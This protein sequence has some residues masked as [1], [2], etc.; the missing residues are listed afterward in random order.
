MMLV[1]RRLPSASAGKNKIPKA[2]GNPLEGGR[3]AAADPQVLF[4]CAQ[5]EEVLRALDRL[6]QAAQKLLKIGIA[7]DKIDFRSI[8]DQQVRR[9]IAEKEM[10]VGPDHFLQ[11]G[12]G[13]LFF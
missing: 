4:A 3:S 12:A 10:L 6:L 11:V 7:F 13:D 8:D 1:S 2:A 5:W 9:G